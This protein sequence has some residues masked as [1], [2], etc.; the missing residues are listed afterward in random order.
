M[1][2]IQL[3]DMFDKFSERHIGVSNE[4]ELKAML[5][6]IGVKVGRR[7][8]LAG[9]SALHPAQETA[10]AARGGHERVR[11]RRP[12]PRAGRAQ[13][14]PAGRSSAWATTPARFPAAI[15]RNV[16]ENPAVVHL[17][18]ALSGRDL[19]GPPRSA[20]ELPDRR[21]L[22]HGHGDRQLLAAGRGARPPPKRC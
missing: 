6:T 11:I 18:H 22:A 9:H 1:T 21:D 3:T 14:L 4:K 16:F 15:A 20:A 13:P 7:A 5:E 17:L 10:R 8:D 19:A 2:S 12:H